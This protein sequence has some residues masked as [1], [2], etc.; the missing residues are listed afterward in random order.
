MSE[1]RLSRE[2]EIA[3]LILRYLEDHPQA[4]DTIEGISQWWLAREGSRYTRA[5]VQRAVTRLLDEDLIVT[6]QPQGSPHCYAANPQKLEEIS[7]ILR[8]S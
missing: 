6:T 7:K 3:L 2:E 1:H 5:E 8:G 4:K